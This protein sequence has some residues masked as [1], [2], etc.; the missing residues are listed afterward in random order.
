[1]DVL[2]LTR[3][4]DE[5]GAQRQIV[6][7]AEGLHELGE[8][9]TIVTFYP[10]GTFAEEL[11]EGP[12][13]HVDLG[14]RHRWD[15][16]G[17]GLRF[18][19]LVRGREPDVV[20]SFLETAN[21]LALT[22][23]LAGTDTALVW[24]VRS[25]DMDLERY[26][27]LEALLYRLNA[28]L[29]GWPDAIVANSHA[30][31]SNRL[32]AGFPEDGFHVVPNGIDVD[33]FAPRP[34][35]GDELRSEWGIAEEAFHVG[36]VARLDPMKGHDVLVEAARPV[37]DERPD[38]EVTAVAPGPE[39]ARA[40][41]RQAIEDAGADG[42]RFHVRGPQDDM[43]AVYAAFDLLVSSSRYG[44]GFSNVLGEAMACQVPVVAT[45]VGDAPTVLGD[46]GTIVPPERPEALA[47]A[48][49]DVAELPEKE[50]QR[51]GREARARI[52]E[53]FTTEALARRTRSILNDAR[54]S[55]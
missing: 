16:P 14:K 36:H 38:V 45:D 40:E 25:S 43:P 9:V 49:L 48:I 53:E 21:L 52:E 33:R 23:R 22:Q 24:G 17:P 50:R 35:A 8:D 47:E 20:Y 41:L 11:E 1:M 5:G 18:L 26:G 30:G 15:L 19:S 44:E 12:I 28:R 4:L 42:D 6:E 10:G 13:E 55:R 7:L 32:E 51:L 2:I 34:R 37:L 3:R 54:G 31:R 27:R 46:A 39:P 29:S